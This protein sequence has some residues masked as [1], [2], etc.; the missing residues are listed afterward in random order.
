MRVAN[1]ACLN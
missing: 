1:Q